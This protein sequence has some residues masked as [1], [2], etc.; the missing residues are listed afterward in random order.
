MNAIR[1]GQTNRFLI[2][3]EVVPPFDRFEMLTHIL[4]DSP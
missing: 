4:A 1:P 3:I 2:T